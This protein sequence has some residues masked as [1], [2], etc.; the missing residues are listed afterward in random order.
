MVVP[1]SSQVII[2]PYNKVRDVSVCSKRLTVLILLKKKIATTVSPLTDIFICIFSLLYYFYCWFRKK[3][4]DEC[5]IF[6][7]FH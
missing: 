7:L 4:I 2:E 1:V 3:G 6:N 5:V